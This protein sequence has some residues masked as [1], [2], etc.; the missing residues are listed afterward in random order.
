MQISI[1]SLCL[2]AASSASAFTAQ[3]PSRTVSSLQM[4]EVNDDEAAMAATAAITT[5]NGWVPD[6]NK[7]AWGLP[8]T[9]DPVENFDPLGFANDCD[10][11]T[12]KRY[13]EA[14]VTHGRVAMLAFI[15]F[16]VQESGFHPLFNLAGKSLGP[17]IRHLD[18]VKANAPIFFE[19]LIIGI[20]ASE[21]SRALAGW[22]KPGDAGGFPGN[23]RPEYFPGDIGF[24]PL[25]LK[26]ESYEDFAEMSTKELQQGR[27]A[28]L[29]VAGFIA[30]ELV[31]GKG[32]LENFGL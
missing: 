32:I 16:L 4:S 9:L 11:L 2:L 31:N 27:L 10:L 28:M 26:P 30:Q 5:S 25:G 23:L 18:V 29:A 24:D 17:A 1:A 3:A 13:R 20:G 8:G 15:G 12:M 19:I 7:F 14:E 6:S 21:F 22:E